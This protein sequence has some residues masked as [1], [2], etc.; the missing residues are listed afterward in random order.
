MIINIYKYE[1]EIKIEFH[2]HE[3]FIQFFYTAFN[4]ILLFYK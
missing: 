2:I 1:S 4:S 3:L